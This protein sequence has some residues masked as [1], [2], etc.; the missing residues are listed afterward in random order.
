MAIPPRTQ[1][2]PGQK[3]LDGKDLFGR[4][5]ALE[6]FVVAMAAAQMPK[7]PAERAAWATEIRKDITARVR[8]MG[9]PDLPVIADA[10]TDTLLAD[11][12]SAAD[13]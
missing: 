1:P 3:P 7:G 5:L 8:K 13:T 6:A 4:M 12:V 9:H 11:I 2:L 10:Y